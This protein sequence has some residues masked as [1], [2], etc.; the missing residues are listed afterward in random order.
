MASSTSTLHRTVITALILHLG[1]ESLRAFMPLL[2]FGLRDRFGW[3]AWGPIG[4][5]LILGLALC[6]F[7]P[8]FGASAISRRIGRSN[9]VRACVLGLVVFRLAAQIWQG[10]PLG[11]L[12]AVSLCLLCFLMFW[13]PWITTPANSSPS[14]HRREVVLGT[15]LGTL[16]SATLHGLMR[17]YDLIWQQDGLHVGLTV[18]LLA[19]LIVAFWRGSEDAAD[20][21]PSSVTFTWF[22]FGPWFFLHLLILLNLGR[23]TVLTGWAQ[24]HA[25]SLQVASHW[26]AF[27]LGAFLSSRS[28]T[29]GTRRV[30]W[31]VAGLTLITVVASPWPVGVLAVVGQLLGPPAAAAVWTQSVLHTSRRSRPAA[32]SMAHGFGMLVLLLLVFLYY[33]GYDMPL[34]FDQ[35]LLMP[36][37]ALLLA[38][39]GWPRKD[40]AHEPTGDARRLPGLF[41]LVGVAACLLVFQPASDALKSSLPKA[42]P[43]PRH[44][45]RVMTYN[46]HCGFGA[47]GYLRL[48]Q[49]AEI[50]QEMN[51]DVIA[52]QEV[53]RGWVM[54][55]GVDILAW[56]AQRLDMEFRYAPTAD[57]L[58]GNATLSRRPITSS[59]T[60][61]FPT[62]AKQQIRRG[63]VEITVTPPLSSWSE[64]PPGDV[65]VI[66]THFHHRR[67][68]SDVRLEQAEIVLDFWQGRPRTLLVG[69]LN[70]TPDS[71]EMQL[72]EQA[73]WIDSVAER[74][75]LP[76]YTF[77]ADRP[78]RR[79][80]YIWASPDL[81]LLEA[82]TVP[83]VASDH[84]AIVVNALP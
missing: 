18:G 57:P 77:R 55:G 28:L 16:L 61:N 45:F 62:G 59:R 47:D 23:T 54:N 32:P 53:S 43:A 21:S 15:L 2:V 70:A 24:G 35:V 72:L 8:T 38:V 49:Q 58:W 20:G 12:I 73:G 56:L 26:L 22:A 9:L 51:V 39:T 74:G 11:N 40:D 14:Q 5:F 69:D 1:I 42:E 84:Y 52:L 36:F 25:A 48:E 66:N 75:Q 79:I 19:I 71:P 46:L 60:L 34:P 67:T 64:T 78:D 33:A 83:S 80:D 4:S 17:T 13:P 6:I 63:L 31:A 27:A 65:T 44:A 81:R 76:G 10:D 30:L 7:L 3:S 37:A 82:T 41:P 68:D 50:M 29:L